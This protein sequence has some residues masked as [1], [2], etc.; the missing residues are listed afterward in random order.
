MAPLRGAILL[1]HRSNLVRMF[2]VV[3]VPAVAVLTTPPVLIALV[4]SLTVVIVAELVIVGLALFVFPP[5][6]LSFSIA[7]W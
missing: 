7:D 4:V 3:M 2:L 6:L 1:D 5:V